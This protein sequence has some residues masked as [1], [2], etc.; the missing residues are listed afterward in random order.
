MI[1]IIIQLYLSLLVSAQAQL[2]PFKL[3]FAAYVFIPYAFFN[4]FVLSKKSYISKFPLILFIIL[5]IGTTISLIYMLVDHNAYQD[6]ENIYYRIR[7]F[8]I[9]IAFA[10]AVYLYLQNKSFRYVLQII[11]IGTTANALMGTY[12]LITSP[13][14]RIHMLFTEPSAAG[15]YYMFIFFI[16]IEKFNNGW[17][18]Y[19]VRYYLLLGLGIESKAQYILLLA[20]GILNNL[21]PKK[22]IIFFSILLLIFYSLRTEITSIPIVQENL[23]VAELYIE[24]GLRNLTEDNQIWTTYV[25]RISAIEGAVRCIAAHPFG[26]GFGGYHSWFRTNMRQTGIDSIET[27]EIFDNKAYA[28]PKSNLLELF[29]S[30]GI[31]GFFLYFYIGSYFIRYRKQYPYIFKSFIMLTLAS[32]LVE[33]NPMYTYLAILMILLEKERSSQ[34]KRR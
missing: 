11:L 24:G 28:T 29:V 31:F 6:S 16:L 2:G 30:T 1:H 17:S 9:D 23:Y 5:L 12:E 21:S 27:N 14:E 18:A 25:T 13:G 10:I 34:E 33:L 20:V 3:I 22:I 26:V 8:A 19:A 32:L 4:Y 15:Y 7:F